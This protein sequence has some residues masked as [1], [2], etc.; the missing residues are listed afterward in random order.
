MSRFLKIVSLSLLIL[1]AAGAL[2]AQGTQPKQAWPAYAFSILLG[3]GTGQYYVGANG[4]PFLIGDLVGVGGV[5]VGEVVIL[6]S[7]ASALSNPTSSSVASGGAGV[8]VGYGLIVVGGIVYLVSHVWEIIDIF[9]AVDKARKAGKVVEVV[10]V[11]DVR[12][13]SFELGVS[14]KY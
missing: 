5:V 8:I 6:S 10:P 3:F 12:R 1:L 9:P 11:V 14:L 7:V 4:T 13:T 2:F